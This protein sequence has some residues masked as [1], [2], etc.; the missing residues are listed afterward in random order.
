[1]KLTSVR[2]ALLAASIVAVGALGATSASA[3]LHPGEWTVGGFQRI[4][5]ISDGS[6]YSTTFSGWSGHWELTGIKEDSAL[7]YGN[8]ASGVGND[9]MVL[10]GLSADWTEWRDGLVK[11]G[12]LDNTA[13]TFFNKTCGPPASRSRSGHA[14]PID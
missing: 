7:V 6:W 1:M 2:T 14:N 13:W 5:L 8:Y 10:R 3:S 11:V 4:C 9:S 12:F